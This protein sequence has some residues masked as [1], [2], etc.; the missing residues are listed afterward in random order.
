MY[1]IKFI[2]QDKSKL[3]GLL[4]GNF[5]QSRKVY[6]F[7]KMKTNV[8]IISLL[9]IVTLIMIF[10]YG[11]IEYTEEPYINWDLK[12]YRAM[13]SI[14]PKLNTDIS[15]PFVYRILGPYIVGLLPLPD[16]MGFYILT[17]VMAFL[18]VFLFY[19]FLCNMGVSANISA[20]TTILF[21]FNKYLFGFNVW[22]FFQI[23][24]L[25][26]LIYLIIL[27]S[28]MV[29]SR[30]IIFGLILV[31]GAFTRE[32]AMLLVPVAFFY[33]FEK[34]KLLQEGRYVLIAV[35]PAILIFL[36]LRILII[37]P[38]NTLLQALII[39]SKKLYSMEALFRMLINSFIPLSLIPIVFY[40]KTIEF[41]RDKRYIYV[42]IML[43]LFSALF[44][45][46]N[47]RLMSPAFI[48]FYWLVA[49]IIDSEIKK[50]KP[51][52]IVILL[53]T[54]LASFHHNI[55]RFDFMTRKL[56]TIVSLN[57]LIIVTILSIVYR[58]KTNKNILVDKNENKTL[59]LGDKKNI[60][61]THKIC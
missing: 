52:L 44:G 2:G 36:L 55:S 4:V 18:C 20:I 60:S 23:N 26:S 41:F 14:S 27:F 16:P 25:L 17:V 37:A 39:H 42:F 15:K 11:K 12:A 5:Y 35:V 3:C 7:I 46:N 51:L 47:E 21:C 58:W 38:G 13:S 9:F 54:F 45:S 28:S 61:R 30:W 32:V 6:F 50:S 10:S 22:D 53:C 24:D 8:K 59:N 43:V 19:F 34:N 33:L 31:L 57:S 49:T 48:V 56:T 29:R 1:K 40:N